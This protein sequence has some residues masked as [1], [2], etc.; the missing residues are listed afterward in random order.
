MI[1]PVDALDDA[2][3][4]AYRHV[5]DH[6]WLEARDLFVAEGR[7]VLQRLLASGRYRLHSVLLTPAALDTLHRQPDLTA[8]AVYVM[9]Q[10]VM[11]QL[12]GFNFHR[13]CLALAHRPRPGDVAAADFARARRLLGLEGVGNPDNVGGLFRT[14]AALGVDA[15]LLDEASGDPFYRKAIRTSMGA[16]LRLPFARIGTWPAACARLREQGF[17]V[18][19]LTTDRMALAVE[20]FAAPAAAAARLLVL[21]GSEGAGLSAATREAADA[22]VRI[23]MTAGADSLNVTVAAGIALARFAARAGT[24]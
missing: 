11:N 5:G 14:A 18:V 1:E 8:H 19:A 13:G 17:L 22:R 2:R 7:L 10:A 16:V 24:L 12:T 6:R 15:V 3:V 20:D 21:V 23:P 9:P 4:D